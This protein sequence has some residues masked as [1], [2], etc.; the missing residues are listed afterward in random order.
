MRK[1]LVLAANPKPT[2]RLRLD[3]EVRDIEEALQRSHHRDQFILTHKWAVRPRDLQRAMLD[4]E[5]QIVHFSGHG[6]EEG[7][8]FESP[9]GDSQ[10]ISGTALASLFKLFVQRT[11]IEC[12]LM[13]GCYSAVQAEVIVQYVPY[14]I[15]MKQ[16]TG[17]RAAIEFAVG[18][19]DALGAGETMEFAFESGKVAMELSG[20]GYEDMPIL[21]K[22]QE[23]NHFDSGSS[24]TVSSNVVSSGVMSSN[25]ADAIQKRLHLERLLSGL[26]GP[27]LSSVITVLRPPAG[28]LPGMSAPQ[29]DRV[30]ALMTWAEGDTGC[31]LEQLELITQAIINPQ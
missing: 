3:Q 14:V 20:T 9:T 15:G 7:L 4:E 28:I 25:A 23:S 6:C 5:P 27:Q 29:S 17:D 16:A 24:D 30:A 11:P 21:L 8:L 1:I 19:Y 13:N 12:L 22:G 18:F 2:A 10:L 31:G 26:P